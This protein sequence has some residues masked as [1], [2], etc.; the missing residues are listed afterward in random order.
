MVNDQLKS[1][2]YHYSVQHIFNADWL[3]GYMKRPHGPIL[4]M[5]TTI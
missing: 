5:L 1:A 3:V 4:L 2:F